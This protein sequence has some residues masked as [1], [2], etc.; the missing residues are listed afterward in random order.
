MH[1]QQLSVLLAA[2]NQLDSYSVNLALSEQG[3]N[4]VSQTGT[5][6]DEIVRLVVKESHQIVLLDVIGKSL[7][8]AK[9]HVEQLRRRTGCHLIAVGD[10]EQISYYKAVRAA[11]A[12]EYLT[13]PVSSSALSSIEFPAEAIRQSG[14]VIAVAGVKGGVGASTVAVNL[15]YAL[16]ERDQS[17]S[18]TDLDFASGSLDLQFDVEGNTALVEMLQFPER[19]EPVVYERSGSQVQSGLTLFTGYMPLDT[20][21]FWPEK[22]ALD[23]FAKFCLNHSNHLI[24]DIPS[25]SLRDQV[26]FGQLYSA[27]VRVLVIEPT[28]ASIRNAGQVIKKLSTGISHG[29]EKQNI[30]V[31]NHTKSDKASLINCNDVHNALGVPAD[32][33]LPFSPSHFMTRD[34]LGKTGL[35]GDRKIKNAFNQLAALIL[36]ERSIASGKLWKRGA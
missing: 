11:G 34:S 16:R 21:P 24:L 4:R 30:L 8:E 2:S 33:V 20:E 35:K 36:D 32:I 25:F 14:K 23:H 22:S 13:N 9:Q 3:Y 18:V 17:V 19:L 12:L 15:A 1:K 26:G 29:S 5:D 7:A 6:H 27:D 10:N 31:L 28:I